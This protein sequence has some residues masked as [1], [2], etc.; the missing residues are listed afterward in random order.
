MTTSIESA[1]SEWRNGLIDVGGNNR[2]L[3]YRDLASTL[4]LDKVPPA[5]FKKL[6]SGSIVRLSELFPEEQDLQ[7]AQKACALLARKQRQAVEEYGIP[8][9]YLAAGMASWDPEGTAALVAAE[10]SELGED[11]Q[12]DGSPAKSSKP[13]YT[14]PRAPVLLRPVEIELR[15]G[16]QQSWDLQLT[17]DFQLNGVLTHVV[18][19]DRFRVDED[20]ILASDEG[21]VSDI[22]IMLDDV[23]N[24]CDDVADF[25]VN[26]TMV[27]GAFSY[28]KQPMVED[29]SDLDALAK[30]DIISALSGDPL[31]A[32]RVRTIKD[33]VTEAFP[34]YQP[35][36]AEFLV[37][38]AD[39]SQSF[40]VNAALAG[41]N[42]VV[43]GP[44][45][46]GK[47]QTIANIIATSAAAGRSVL[48]V[49]QKRAAVSAVLDR[50]ERIDLHHLVLDVF[51]ASNS[52]RFI[53]DQLQDALDRQ[54]TAGL[55]R[56]EELHFTL[57]NARDLL[58]RH[59][60]AMHDPSRGWGISVA[61]LL[62]LSLSIPPE[63]QSKATMPASTL[64]Q[65]SPN[66]LVRYRAALTDLSGLGALNTGWSTTPGW[67]P[68]AITNEEELRAL[69]LSL[70]DL[71]AQEPAV[72]AGLKSLADAL[73][74]PSPATWDEAFQLTR[75][76][77]ELERVRNAAPLVLDPQLTISEL[78]EALIAVNKPFRKSQTVRVPW[79]VRRSGTRRARIL[80]GHLPRATQVEVLGAA[81]SLRS[82]WIGQ[83]NFAIQLP[84]ASVGQHAQDFLA[85]LTHLDL[86]LFAM[87]TASA[88][89]DTLAS[90]FEQ[91]ASDPRRRVMPRA[92]ARRAELESAG[93]R[94]LLL[95]LEVRLDVNETSANMA[96]HLLDRVVTSTLLNDAMLFD[97]ALAA[98]DGRE[99]NRASADFQRHDLGHLEANAVRIRRLAAERLKRALDTHPEQHV[100]LKKEVTRK[101]KFT[102]VRKLLRELPE[103]ILAAKPVWAMSPLQVSRL[104]PREQLFDVV[105]FDEASQ[106]KPADAIPAILRGSQL[107]VAG[108]S[109]QLPPTEFFAKTLEDPDEAD[110]SDDSTFDVPLEQ[111]TGPR[112]LGSLTRDAESILFAMDRL[113][114]GQSRRLLWHYRSRDE[115]LIAVSNRHV[116]DSSLTTFPA[117]DTPDA[118]THIEVP[119]SVG[120]GGGTN[121]PEGEVAAVVNAVRQHA[122][123]RPDESL[124]VI[125]FGIKHQ[126]RLEGALDQ[127]FADDPKLFE[128][129]NAK[130]PFFVKSIERVQGDERD[131]IILTV[132]YGKTAEGK[133]RLFWGPLLQSGG[134]R[135]LN[136]A[137]SRARLRLTLVSSFSADDL[138][139]DGHE[140][141][142]YNLMY[143][144]VRFVASGG[145]EL[146][147]GP[148]RT[149]ALN[150]F[151]IDVRNRLQA[152]G[153]VLDS[154]VGVG[155]YRLDFAARHPSKPGRHV[156]AIEADGAA[157]HSGHTARERD[158]LRQQLL[159]RRG[160]VF[161]RIWSTDWFND[162]DAEV[163][164]V[165]SAF[166]AAVA[167]VDARVSAPM[168]DVPAAW[169][170]PVGERSE[171]RPIFRAGGS[172]D[173]YD[174]ATLSAVVR[175]IRSD[176]TVRNADDEIA[177]VMRELGF[178]RRGPKIIREIG[179]AQA[180]VDGIYR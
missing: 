105:I 77:S 10:N 104:L 52:R 74:L 154:Q 118:I 12:S 42:L 31:A 66:D 32:E 141:L 26:P 54:S 96:G 81:Y 115:R 88:R 17:D 19:A 117:A 128:T 125:A 130:E 140:S 177:V 124:G 168:A 69:D 152:A 132:G 1:A 142:G 157:Y 56:T 7:R 27:I 16:A 11:L 67:S 147:G 2:L 116:Y 90:L 144:F 155:S 106:V 37:L 8:V 53:A 174:A 78:R 122:A 14:R 127:A 3:N 76:F 158:R 94:P 110:E 166:E 146:T 131:A 48:F 148:N 57:A 6:I 60:A 159:E 121:S 139:E 59:N 34:D 80:V 172:I 160:W 162:A 179:A 24:R 44:P 9:T 149:I 93:L 41:R 145:K 112:K 39:A 114:A 64:M 108:D 175:W 62:S 35:I 49:A 55:A 28:A 153:L 138:A 135:R 102:P 65:W 167:R 133:L 40:V 45:G 95:E 176:N 18:N 97:P 75:Q 63:V 143:R 150:P 72:L 79:S 129:L 58:V 38:D 5:A 170:L 111:K 23:V 101:I 50:L 123:A 73:G 137:I 120:I 161:H 87:S 164:S 84:W 136:V 98:V 33:D 70:R 47:S 51:A 29:V 163:A 25:E 100:M 92:A 169:E 85:K 109:R 82:N 36:A 180:R 119:F 173:D 22:A 21:E 126:H 151:E 156:L 13:K 178:K 99:L 15:R 20:S 68:A 89:L 165:V 113:L 46:T 107:I 4:V 71:Q 43:E 134:E 103:V 61:D 30:S 91:L 86:S 83:T 171:P